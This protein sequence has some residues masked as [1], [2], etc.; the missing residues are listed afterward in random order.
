VLVEQPVVV[1]VEAM[2]TACTLYCHL[3]I[4]WF[5]GGEQPPRTT[6][7]MAELLVQASHAVQRER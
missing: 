7:F 5:D 4:H 1:L 2:G 3:E 6:A